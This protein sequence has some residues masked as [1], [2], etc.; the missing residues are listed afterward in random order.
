[1]KLSVIIPVYNEIATIAEVLRQVEALQ[2]DK[3][4]IIIDNCST[5]GT[6][7]F[8]QGLPPERAHVILQPANYNKGTSVRTGLK[9]AQ[10]EYTVI[11]DADL[12]YDPQD[13]L[14]LLEAVQR[15]QTDA[16]FGARF[17]GVAGEGHGPGL[18]SFGR[19]RLNDVFRWLYR[20]NLRDVATCYKLVRTALLQRLT[21]RSSGFDL[22][23]ELAAK[24]VKAGARI[25]EVPI[26][27]RPRT[28]AEGKKL[29]WRD[30]WPVL[31]SL[32]KYRFVN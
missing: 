15:E 18:H 24:L 11:Q 23:Y 26:S 6:R 9:L 27:Y 20:R 32:L 29:S 5:D 19:S 8:L 28:A 3:E 31:C 30:G 16:A 25:I 1:M 22:D 12:E 4:I 13:I 10:G 2:V 21:L 17:T 14:R 7:E